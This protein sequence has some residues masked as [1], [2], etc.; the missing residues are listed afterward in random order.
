[1]G[2]FVEIRFHRQAGGAVVEFRQFIEAFV[3]EDLVPG[4]LPIEAPTPGRRL[5]PSF[6]P[7]QGVGLGIDQPGGAKHGVP[8]EDQAFVA[9]R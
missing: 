9:R 2:D 3:E 4:I 1:M 6:D 8:P 5:S 7:A